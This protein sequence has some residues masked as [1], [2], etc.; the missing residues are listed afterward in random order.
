M[1][2]CVSFWDVSVLGFIIKKGENRLTN[3]TE[4]FRKHEKDMKGLKDVA[5]SIVKRKN[6]DIV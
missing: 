1:C 5:R 3:V 4:F 2:V 6:T